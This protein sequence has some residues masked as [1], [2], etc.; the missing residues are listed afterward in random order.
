MKAGLDRNFKPARK[1][2]KCILG[3]AASL[4][5]F[6]VDK[7]AFLAYYVLNWFLIDAYFVPIKCQYSHI[8]CFLMFNEAFLASGP[9]LAV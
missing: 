8:L 4:A 6:C 1:T 5:C 9:R 2:E 3:L 7:D